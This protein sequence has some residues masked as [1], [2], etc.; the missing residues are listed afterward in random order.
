MSMN[1]LDV[2]SQTF[3]PRE[4]FLTF[5]TFELLFWCLCNKGTM[6]LCFMPFSALLPTKCF[7]AVMTLKWYCRLFISCLY[8]YRF[9]TFLFMSIPRL[10]PIIYIGTMMTLEFWFFCTTTGW[11]GCPTKFWLGRWASLHVSCQRFFSIEKPFH[12]LCICSQFCHISWFLPGD[13]SNE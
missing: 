1:Q 5:R 3:L 13:S 10:L 11:W 8:I 9:V 4:T 7:S 2:V 6:V 12:I